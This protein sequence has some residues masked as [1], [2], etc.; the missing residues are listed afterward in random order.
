MTYD[1]KEAWLNRHEYCVRKNDDTDDESW[2]AWDTLDYNGYKVVC[3]TREEAI[4]EA[5]NFLSEENT[6]NPIKE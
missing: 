5:F 2:Q 3:P 6:I 4:D 1:Q